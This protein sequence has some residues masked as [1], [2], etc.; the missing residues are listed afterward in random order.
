MQ[1][2]LHLGAFPTAPYPYNNHCINPEPSA[3]RLYM[4]YGPLLDAM[5]GKKWVLAPRCV[6][7]TTP[8]V[9]VNLFEVPAGYALP[10]SFGGQAATATVKVRNIPGLDK[11]KA[12]A[13]HPG[14]EIAAPV[15][16]TV[17]EGALTLTIPLKRGC[18]MV[19]LTK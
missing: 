11:L 3:D 13:L 2:H 19:Q 5:R 10:V 18:A 4:D 15:A 6:E 12:V 1:R 14:V 7:T 8:G 16:S 17:E 9:K